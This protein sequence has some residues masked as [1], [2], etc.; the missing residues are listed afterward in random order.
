MS[1]AYRHWVWLV[2]LLGL[3]LGSERAEAAGPEAF[4]VTYGPGA[5][6]WELFGHNALWLRDEQTGLDHSFSF[7]Y[8]ELD[9]PGFHLDF[10]R[11]IMLYY[12]AAMPIE[13]EL[14]FYRSRDRSIQVQRLA[15]SPS[16]VHHLHG[17]LD[18]AIF[19]APQYYQYDYFFANCS[20]WLRDLL[21]EVLDGELRASIEPQPARLNFR[22]HTRRLTAHQFWL[23]H[24]ILALLGMEIDQPRTAWEEAF[25]PEALAQSLDTVTIDGQA[26][27]VETHWL[28]QSE[29][30]NPP[31]DATGRPVSSALLG[32]LLAV[33]LWLGSRLGSGATQ[34]RWPSRLIAALLGVL[35][36]APMIMWLFTG[37]EATHNNLM[38]LLLNPFWLLLWRSPSAPF[39]AVVLMVLAS[40]SAVAAIV[41]SLPGLIQDRPDQVLLLLPVIAALLLLHWTERRKSLA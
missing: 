29:R 35:G 20:T 4:L 24:G 13:R 25:L 5:E 27:V 31:G 17:L 39:Q 3:C 33:L 11:G 22:D 34:R 19:P 40:F 6:V 16:Q 14:A 37:H 10:A 36:L 28:H 32:L 23:H 9:R 30:F 8:F 1:A 26:L 38:I 21:D 12:G 2:A 41:L 7:G 18:A 15:L